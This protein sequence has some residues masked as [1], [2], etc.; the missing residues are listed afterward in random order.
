MRPTVEEIRR[1]AYH[2]WERRGWDHGGDRDDW[3]AAETDLTFHANYRTIVE[4]AL[5]GPEPRVLGDA[6]VRRCR[7]CERTDG[8]ANFGA[9]RPVFAD[10]ASLLTAQVCDDC[11][12]DWRDS[13]DDDF[14][15]FWARLGRQAPPVAG[16][17]PPFSVAAFKALTAGA[18]LIMPGSE[19]R[20]F[21]DT[22]EWVSNPDHD[23]DDQLLD[24]TE[25]R[26]YQA[27]F[28]GEP[29]RA[30]LAHRVDDEA[31]VPYML[32]SLECEGI[33]VQVP[34][35]M[36]LRDEDLDGRTI[37]RPERIPVAGYGPEFREARGVLLP[38]SVSAR[39]AVRAYRHAA[40]AS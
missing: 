25:C 9:P 20:Y 5:E 12:A 15:D 23:S 29:P 16:G 26:I 11:Q 24:A 19:L 35:P 22:L 18:L 2:R 7:F 17:R 33:M 3:Y 14:R 39:R 31:P 13:L 34:L 21:V 38:L 28:L 37:E 4:Y 27:P 1:A 30:T 40:I 10:R 6:P 32:F 8:P 36:C